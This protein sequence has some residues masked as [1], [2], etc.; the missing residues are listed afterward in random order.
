MVMPNKVVKP[1]IAAG[2]GTEDGRRPTV[3]PAP[4]AANPEISERPKPA[5]LILAKRDFSSESGCD[6]SSGWRGSKAT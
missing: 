3:V 2:A 1:L 5:V 4:A 6:S